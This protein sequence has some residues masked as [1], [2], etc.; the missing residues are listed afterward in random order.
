MLCMGLKPVYDGDV[1]LPSPVLFMSGHLGD[2]SEEAVVKATAEGLLE[3]P[4]TSQ[5]LAQM[6]RR[7]IER[8]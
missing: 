1:H 3:K 7:C 8:A 4:F 2:T 6:V 5:G